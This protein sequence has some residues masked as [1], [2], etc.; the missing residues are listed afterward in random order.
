[1][2]CGDGLERLGED[3]VPLVWRE[4]GRGAD[5]VVLSQLAHSRHVALLSDRASVQV[6]K[7]RKY[8]VHHLGRDRR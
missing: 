1:M 4:H 6:S 2:V 5:L 7:T 8:A 3:M